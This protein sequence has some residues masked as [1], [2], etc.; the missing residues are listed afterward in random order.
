MGVADYGDELRLEPFDERIVVEQEPPVPKS[1]V[2]RT[3]KRMAVH[4]PPEHRLALFL[5]LL[6]RTH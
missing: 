3:A 6:T 4:D 2:S 1:I 5:G